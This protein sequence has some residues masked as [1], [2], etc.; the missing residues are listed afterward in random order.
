MPTQQY[1]H[2]QDPPPLEFVVKTGKEHGGCGGELEIHISLGS[3]SGFMQIESEHPE[4]MPEAGDTPSDSKRK[5]REFTNQ[6][7]DR[8]PWQYRCG[9]CAYQ[10]EIEI[11]IDMR[12]RDI[13]GSA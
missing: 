3:V 13:E 6:M 11:G 9:G 5:S 4:L 2:R 8:A 7:F 12:G 1:H 10:S